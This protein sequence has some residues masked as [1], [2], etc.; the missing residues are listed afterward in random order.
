MNTYTRYNTA[1]RKRPKKPVPVVRSS[2]SSEDHILCPPTAIGGLLLLSHAFRAFHAC[3]QYLQGPSAYDRYTSGGSVPLEDTAV[4]VRLVC[5]NRPILGGLWQLVCVSG[6]YCLLVL[7]CYE[8]LLLRQIGYR[9]VTTGARGEV[10][11]FSGIYSR[12]EIRLTHERS[13]I[14]QQTKGVQ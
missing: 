2:A 1:R 6:N 12:H 3:A 8:Q 13:N 5:E 7:A 4:R 14:L 11:R 10:T 9:V